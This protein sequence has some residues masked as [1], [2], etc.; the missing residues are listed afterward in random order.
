MGVF[1]FIGGVYFEQ[2]FG[3]IDCFGVID[4][5]VDGYIGFVRNVGF[6]FGVGFY[7]YFVLG[8][9]QFFDGFGGGG[10]MGFFV[11]VFG[12]DCYFYF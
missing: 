7:Y 1:D 3:G 4:V 2:D 12:G 8:C 10:D 6:D 9:Y 11:L 5:G